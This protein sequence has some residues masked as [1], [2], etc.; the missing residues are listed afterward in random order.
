MGVVLS[1]CYSEQT[2]EVAQKTKEVS[3]AGG[4]QEAGTVSKKT[5]TLDIVRYVCSA[6][7]NMFYTPMAGRSPE[8][9]TRSTTEQ[10]GGQRVLAVR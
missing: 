10:W 8:Y 4:T 2:L 1:E 9:Y 5:T 3:D 7:P 6:V